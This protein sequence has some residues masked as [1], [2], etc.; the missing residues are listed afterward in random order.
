MQ[1]IASSKSSLPRGPVSAA[2]LKTVL[3][4]CPW[5]IS[6]R[7]PSYIIV[8]SSNRC[9]LR[10]PLCATS[11]N[12]LR[13]KGEMTLATFERLLGQITWPVKMLS[14][15][16]AGEP[17]MNNEIFRMVELA[18]KKNIPSC[19]ETNGMLLDTCVPKIVDSGLRRLNIALDGM[20]QEV[21]SQYRI[22]ADFKRVRDAVRNVCAHKKLRKSRYPHIALQFLVMRQNEHQIEDFL[23][24]AGDTGVDEVVLKTVNLNLGYWLSQPQKD[25]MAKK[26]LPGKQE[27]N[28]YVK[29][30]RGFT[31]S[32][33]LNP[34]CTYVLTSPAVLWNGDVILCCSDF[35]GKYK[36][37]N[38]NE[39]PLKLIW[40]DKKVEHVRRRALNRELD[41]C[42]D[43]TY[44]DHLNKHIFL[45]NELPR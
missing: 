8:E 31:F 41:I 24:F 16:F 38:I 15:S 17:L 42:R 39:T 2:A 37:G 18:M 11:G 14:F 44:T 20:D 29:D 45:K 12:M 22:G 30:D 25:A 3:K 32:A 34:L 40:R 5:F 4:F 6:N 43:C 7:L 36:I 27:F 26:F 33:R 19:I 35:N 21:L 28:R 9:M 1:K 23:K 10:C 13:D